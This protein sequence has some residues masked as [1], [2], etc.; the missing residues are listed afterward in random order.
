MKGIVLG[1]CEAE[2]IKYIK[3]IYSF[4]KEKNLTGEFIVMGDSERFE[5][6]EVKRR[7]FRFNGDKIEEVEGFSEREYDAVV[8]L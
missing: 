1:N 8:I 5:V 7:V 6:F 4:L 3:K 2:H